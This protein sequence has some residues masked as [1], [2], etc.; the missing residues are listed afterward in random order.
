MRNGN[1][2]A[3]DKYRIVDVRS[4]T[5]SKPTQEMMDAM[6]SVS[7]YKSIKLPFSVS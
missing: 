7:V 6:M 5:V 4:D 2:A 3:V 1:S